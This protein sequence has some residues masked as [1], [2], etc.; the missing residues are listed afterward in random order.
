MPI[1]GSIHSKHYIPGKFINATLDKSSKENERN[2][3]FVKS[4]NENFYIV[5]NS[6]AIMPIVGITIGS[7][8]HT[9]PLQISDWLMVIVLASAVFWIEEFRKI[10]FKFRSSKNS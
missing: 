3:I 8:L 4:N 2:I 9:V 5:Q 1:K 7:L 10:I 6:Y